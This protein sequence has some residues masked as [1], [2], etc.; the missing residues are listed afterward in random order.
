M[1]PSNVFSGLSSLRYLYL[2]DN[3]I[4]VIPAVLL[5]ELFNL[6]Y[7]NLE[8]NNLVYLPAGLFCNNAQLIGLS[9]R[10]NQLMV[11]EHMFD[12]L[13][14]L[15]YLI[16]D[17]ELVCCVKPQ[18]VNRC[19]SADMELCIDDGL[20][21]ETKTMDTISSCFQLIHSG[22]LTVCLWIIGPST[23]L[24]NGFVILYRSLI[25]KENI[26]SAHSLLVLNLGISDFIMGVYMIMIG[27]VAHDYSGIYAWNSQSWRHSPL[28]NT[29]G[30][31]ATM[32]SE[33]STFLVLLVTI[34]RF[35]V[36]VLPLSRR[37]ITRRHAIYICTVLWCISLAI[38]SIPLFIFQ[39]YFKGEFYSQSGVCLALPL[40]SKHQPGAEYSFAIF[41]CLNSTIFVVILLAQ[42]YIFYSLRKRCRITSTANRQRENV[43]ATLLFLVVATNFFCWCPI[44]VMGTYVT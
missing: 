33:M 42:I 13:N 5:S 22:A 20:C 10:D 36:I 3:T 40:T 28:C 32:S 16:T 43:I 24:G 29:A 34:D 23:L 21:N 19:I 35:T 44:G 18:S 9:L 14:N 31:L 41:A 12:G 38:A 7:L 2:Q 39:S 11:E 26:N 6:T 4:S 15:E 27:A 37:H 1:L 17:S 30:I 25:D 8:N